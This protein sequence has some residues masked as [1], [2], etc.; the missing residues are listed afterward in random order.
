LAHFGSDLGRN[1]GEGGFWVDLDLWQEQWGPET[2][3]KKVTYLGVFFSALKLVNKV[4]FLMKRNFATQKLLENLEKMPAF[5]RDGLI[6][7]G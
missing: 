1:G 6:D 7:G 4:H 5:G 2:A 3:W